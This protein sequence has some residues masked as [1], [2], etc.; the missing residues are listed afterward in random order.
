MLPSIM[1]Y[2]LR[3]MKQR[4]VVWFLLNKEAVTLKIIP[5]V[6]NTVSSPKLIARHGLCFYI[7]TRDH[8]MLMDLGPNDTFLRN[9]AA[10]DIDISEID[11]VV[12]SHGHSDHVGGLKAFLNVNDTAK[13]YMNRN[14]MDP[15]FIKVEGIPCPI[16]IDVSLIDEENER[17]VFTD[18][19][20]KVDGEITLFAGVN[21]KRAYPK[22]NEVMYVRKGGQLVVDEFV[23]EQHMLLTNGKE[24]TLL[25]GCAH[26]GIANILDRAVEVCQ[27]KPM[28]VIG[29]FHMFYE[30]TNSYESDELI[31]E[32][33]D[34]LEEWDKTTFYTCHCTGQKAF[35]KLKERVGNRLQYLSTGQKLEFLEEVEGYILY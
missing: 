25:T 4:F 12:L 2:F 33:A 23:H 10:L 17:F 24:W 9:A 19:F 5:L 3:G 35:D 7:E 32:T 16:G 21:S 11:M 22:A 18:H 30:P 8:K 29:G 1:L 31:E 26:N 14:V 15:H 20:T 13:I 28:L 6:E 34:V 27:E